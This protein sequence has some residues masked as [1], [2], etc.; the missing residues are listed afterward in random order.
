MQKRKEEEWLR[1]ITQFVQMNCVL[2]IVPPIFLK[3]VHPFKFD[4]YVGKNA[5]IISII[6]KRGVYT[7]FFTETRKIIGLDTLILGTY[8]V[9]KWIVWIL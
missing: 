9:G 2:P 8:L 4:F 6:K 7:P 3:P 1:R 5:W